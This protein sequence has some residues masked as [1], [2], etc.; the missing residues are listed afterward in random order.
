MMVDR[1]VCLNL[2]GGACP[3]SDLIYLYGYGEENEYEI[4]V[5]R[6]IITHEYLHDMLH[7]NDV[8]IDLHHKIIYEVQ[9]YIFSF[10]V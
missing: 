8:P 4:E 5:W 7:K 3:K 1:S 9:P 2:R 6:G 10:V